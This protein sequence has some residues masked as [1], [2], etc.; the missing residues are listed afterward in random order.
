[1]EQ[2]PLNLTFK[3]DRTYIHGTSMLDESTRILNRVFQGEVSMLEFMIHKMTNTNLLLEL[4]DLKSCHSPIK[5][6]IAITRLV[7]N[8][9]LIL[10]RI[11]STSG[12][13]NKRSPYNEAEIVGLCE[14]NFAEKKVLLL[15]DISTYSAI[16]ILVAMNKA[17]HIQTLEKPVDSSWVFCRW[18][19]PKWPLP[20]SLSGVTISIK[21]AL[22]SRLTKSEVCLNGAIL[23]N[24]YFSAKA[25]L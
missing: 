11:C 2:Y 16:E 4:Y 25:T 12:Q 6:D 22:G 1:M 24:I 14:I 5:D 9:Q 20:A 3:G 15:S 10:G 18:D 8:G 7:I 17:L 13:P 23:G 19:S 21:Q